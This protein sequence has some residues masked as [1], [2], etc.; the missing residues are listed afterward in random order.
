MEKWKKCT[1]LT[2]EQY[3]DIA[4]TIRLF[5]KDSITGKSSTLKVNQF[6]CASS[7]LNSYQLPV[8][9]LLYF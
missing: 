2:E 9:Y 1:L 8:F 7:Y 3:L 6:D 5:E 4:E